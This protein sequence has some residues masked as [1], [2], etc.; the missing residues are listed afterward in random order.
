[1][2][3]DL[4]SQNTTA[5]A[6]RGKR[7]QATVSPSEYNGKGESAADVRQISQKTN[8]SLTQEVLNQLKSRFAI[9]LPKKESAIKDSQTSAG[10]LSIN[11]MSGPESQKK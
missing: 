1:M 2:I 6:N 10:V 4:A 11:R 7:N 9:D 5:I 3:G 8:A